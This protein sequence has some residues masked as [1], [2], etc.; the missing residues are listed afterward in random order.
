MRDLA[1]IN[2]F[3]P[4]HDPARLYQL[5]KRR[6]KRKIIPHLLSIDTTLTTH[7]RLKN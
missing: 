1:P 7:L 2:I 5:I 4:M 3:F 6:K